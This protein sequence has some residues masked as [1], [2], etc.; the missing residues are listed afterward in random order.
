M[1]TLAEAYRQ[2][3]LQQ[4]EQRLR[5][6]ITGVQCS[7]EA[8]K[9]QGEPVTKLAVARM[10]GISRGNMNFHPEVCMIFTQCP[11]WT[12]EPPKKRR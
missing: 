11:K 12:G 7:I 6:M 5:T 9:K 8:L 10:L 3:L 4:R 1:D 2:R